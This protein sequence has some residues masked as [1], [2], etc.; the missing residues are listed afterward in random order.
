MEELNQRFQELPDNAQIVVMVSGALIG[1]LILILIVMA[2]L[3][4]VRGPKDD[5]GSGKIKVP[6][7]LPIAPI[8]VMNDRENA[9]YRVLLAAMSEF[10]NY[11]VHPKIAT[12]AMLG[13]REEEHPKVAIAIRKSMIKEAHDFIIVDRA[14]YPVAVIEL[15]SGDDDER[16]EQARRSGLPIVRVKNPHIAPREISE[17]LRKILP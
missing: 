13:P 4:A 6:K 15:D 12:T 5:S 9:L 1:T 8:P 14:R 17:R 11:E 2:I 10:P 3:S 16:E 7:R